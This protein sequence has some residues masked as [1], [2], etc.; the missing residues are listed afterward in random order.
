MNAEHLAICGSP[1]WAALLREQVLPWTLEDVALG[2]RVIEIGPGPGA[3]TTVLEGDGRRLVAAE[4]DLELATALGD[5]FRGRDVEVVVADA[6][7]LPF[8]TGSFT[9]AVSFT[10]LHHVPTTALQDRLLREL[11]R[12]VQA[13]GVVAGSDSLATERR[14]RIHEDDLYCPIAPASFPDRLVEAGFTSANVDVLDEPA[15]TLGGFLRFRGRV[16]GA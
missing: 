1:G 8:A 3:A 13:G 2:D 5:R 11:R 9:A 6:V 16:P 7:A 12:V 4:L 15:D 10:M 14:R